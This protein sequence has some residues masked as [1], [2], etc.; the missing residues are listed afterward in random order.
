MDAGQHIKIDS[1]LSRRDSYFNL[2]DSRKIFEFCLGIDVSITPRREP[3]QTI[4]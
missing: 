2:L 1:L 4:H 3:G